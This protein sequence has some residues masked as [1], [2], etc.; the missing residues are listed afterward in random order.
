VKADIEIGG[1]DQ[2]F[3]LVVG[4]KIQEEYGLEPQAVLTCPS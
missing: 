3:N 1:D 2:F 4:R